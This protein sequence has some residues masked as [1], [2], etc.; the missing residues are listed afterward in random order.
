MGFLERFFNAK[1]RGEGL[2]FMGIVVGLMAAFGGILFGYDTGTI[3][4][5]MAM[6]Y[7]LKRFP[8]DTMKP[9][10]QNGQLMPGEF[11]L[12][13]LSLIVSILSVGTFCGALLAPIP[14]DWIGRRWTLIILAFVV[15]NVGVIMQTAATAIPLM[16]VGRVFAG[17]GVGLISSVIPLYQAETAPKW[18]RGALISCY[19]WAITVGL[20]LASVVNQCTK[21]RNDSGS[22]RIPIAVQ[23]AWS[24]ILTIGMLLLP[25]TPR[26]WVAKNEPEKAKNSLAR[27]RRLP[28]DHPEI[29]KE[30]QEIQLNHE[31]ELS[32]GKGTWAEVFRNHNRQWKRLAMGVLTQAFQQLTGINF[33]FY[34]GTTAFKSAGISNP[35]T[36]TLATNITNVGATLPGIA[37][38]EWVGR[39]KLLLGGSV[40]MAVSQLIIAIVGTAD[41]NGAAANKVLVGFS[42]IFVAFFAATWGT[43]AWVVCS[44][45]FA[46]KVRQKSLAITTASNWL[47]NFVIAFVTPYLVNPGKGNANLGPKVFYIWGGCNVIA[48]FFTWFMVYET[49][50]L[51]LEECDECWST[52]PHAWQSAK[53]VPQGTYTRQPLVST[54]ELEKDPVVMVEERSV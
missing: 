47:L 16:C 30:Y 21:D 2:A 25:E 8:N 19:Q 3:S 18:L 38:I 50:G 40:G 24:I 46:L 41:P 5:I 39:R 51:T 26:F 20:F 23:F 27:L 49:K 28:E 33:I 53:F 54:E 43:T 12:D 44:E 17:L 37:L 13:E 48:I 1:D 52:V 45:A 34:Y 31:Y 42:C 6:D 35:F 7:V 14:S 10:Y 22:Y 9:Y 32:F 36:I 11:T 4:G 15:F 29:V